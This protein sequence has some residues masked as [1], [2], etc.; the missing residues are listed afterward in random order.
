MLAF[1]KKSYRTVFVLIFH[2][3]LGVSAYAQSGGARPIVGHLLRLRQEYPG[4]DADFPAARERRGGASARRAERLR[5]AGRAS[6][7]A[8]K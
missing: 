5:D 6:E 1:Y 3:L 8:S 2:L 7:R 4:R